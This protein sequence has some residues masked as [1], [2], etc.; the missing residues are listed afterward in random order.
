MI[1]EADV[2]LTD[3]A[4]ALLC[5]W[6]I[7]RTARGPAR[8]VRPWA[9][10]LLVSVGL[11]ALIGGT[12]HGFA[13]DHAGT[14]FHWLWSATMLCLGGAGLA[15][16]GLAAA[17]ALTPRGERW[18]ISGVALLL[19]PYA[20]LVVIFPAPFWWALAAYLPA[21]AAFLGA[22]LFD[23]FRRQDAT[24]AAGIASVLIT[25]LAA[26]VQSRRIDSGPLN[27]NVA[28]HLL[29]M[30]AMLLIP[31]WTRSEARSHAQPS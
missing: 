10:L 18:V 23:A 20:V 17:I 14:A 13:P 8:R 27:H 24:H 16:A 7:A 2:A 9:T 22:L 1:A 25:V 30:G 5:A 15:L 19:I 21:L 31:L 11:G 29:Q 28:Y 26:L 6:C 3:Y 4:L 12:A